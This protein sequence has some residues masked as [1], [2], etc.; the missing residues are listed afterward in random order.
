MI[1]RLTRLLTL[2]G[3]VVL[4]ATTMGAHRADAEFIVDIEQDGGNVSVSGSG[5]LDLANLTVVGTGYHGASGMDPSQPYLVIGDDSTYYLVDVYSGLT[6]PSNFGPGGDNYPTTGTTT[7]LVGFDGTDLYVPSGYVSGAPLSASMT[8]DSTTL[9]GLG[10]QDGTYTYTLGSNPT[11]DSFVIN[12]GPVAATPLPGS[13]PLIAG[14]LSLLVAFGY[15]RR[16][17]SS[18]NF[19]SA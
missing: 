18:P 17:K 3:I 9:A 4:I 12:V 6:G 19:I 2:G 16:R 13:L 1:R 14:P 7:G 10:L 15:W 11:D 8:F 5:S